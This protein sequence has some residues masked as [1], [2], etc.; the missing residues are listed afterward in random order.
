MSNSSRRNY[1]LKSTSVLISSQYSVRIGADE[2]ELIYDFSHQ[3]LTVH[4]N[5]TLVIQYRYHPSRESFNL[6]NILDIAA[7]FRQHYYNGKLQYKPTMEELENYTNTNT[8]IQTKNEE[9]I[10]DKSILLTN[11]TPGSQLAN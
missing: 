11:N 10:R 3:F 4:I 6:V 5:T 2:I 1:N 8:Q 9:Q 7:K